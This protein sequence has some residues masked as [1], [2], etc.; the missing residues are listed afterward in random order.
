MTGSRDK[1]Q[2]DIKQQHNKHKDSVRKGVSGVSFSISINDTHRL[3]KIREN[4][5][6]HYN[7]LKHMKHRGGSRISS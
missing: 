4:S 1:D 7:T 6:D 5:N 2:L 3:T